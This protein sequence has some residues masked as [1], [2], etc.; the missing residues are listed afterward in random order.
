[1]RVGVVGCGYW[2]SKHIRVMSSVPEVDKVVIIEPDARR[3]EE[4]ARSF[5]AAGVASSMAEGLQQVDAVVVATPARTHAHLTR[6]ALEAGKH[7]L[8]EKPMATS[9][10][11]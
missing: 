8:V 1:M 7:V 9:T 2:G 6:I 4:M 11:D 5:P 3:R 10:V